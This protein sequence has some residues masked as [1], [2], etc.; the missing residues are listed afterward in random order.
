M[1]KDVNGGKLIKPEI[2]HKVRQFDKEREQRLIGLLADI[3]LESTLKEYYEERN[4]I[5]KV[6][7]SGA[8]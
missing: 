5:F 7:Q 3:L 1:E 8:K 4:Q 2:N 6:Q